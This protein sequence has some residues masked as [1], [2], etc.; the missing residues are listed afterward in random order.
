MEKNLMKTY[1]KLIVYF[2]MLAIFSLF[3]EVKI[4][5]PIFI[6]IT[7]MCLPYFK[8]VNKWKIYLFFFLIYGLALN[9]FYINNFD[10]NLYIKFIVNL[11]FLLIVPSFLERLPENP[12][13]KDKLKIYLELIIILS[14]IQII[15]VYVVQNIPFTYFLNIQSSIDAYAITRNVEPIFG[16]SNKNIWASKLF[17]I[18]LIYVYFILNGKIKIR[19]FL[20]LFLSISNIVLLLSRTA[21]IAMVIPLVYI[22]YKKIFSRN[23]YIRFFSLF[24]VPLLL[25]GLIGLV[26]D[27]I[28][29]VGDPSEDGGA[30]RIALWKAFFENFNQTNYLV[31]NGLYS[32]Y[33]FL[34]EY[35]P[36]LVNTNM[37]N[38]IINIAMETGIL[39]ITIYILFFV[40]LFKSFLLNLGEY[41]VEFLLVF[42]VP[43]VIILSLQYLGYDNDIVLYFA[44]LFLIKN[45]Y[46][47]DLEKNRG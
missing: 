42:I 47:K 32:S 16:H 21:Q 41:K 6:L 18:Q 17:L 8:N 39:G 43:V 34:M 37:H 5:I 20:M 31:G 2:I 4:Y 7:F 29:R 45:F 38:F 24:L 28:L 36:H 27:V 22:F 44:L 19:E 23:S 12:E 13:I 26:T 9:I 35:V 30:S 15:Y 46:M 25:I 3:I 40:F 33:Q 10:I 14:S 1:D 11:S